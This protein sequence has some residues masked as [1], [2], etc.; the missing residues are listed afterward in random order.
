MEPR[1]IRGPSLTISLLFVAEGPPDSFDRYSY[2]ENVKRDDW[3]WIA[4]MKAL[5]RSQWTRTQLERLRKHDWLSR[6]QRSGS[7]LTE[8]IGAG[9]PGRIA[10]INALL[11][12]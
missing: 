2:V 5:Y 7:S 12:N 9:K 3:L 11:Q 4:L 8:P 6:F 1:K 10:L